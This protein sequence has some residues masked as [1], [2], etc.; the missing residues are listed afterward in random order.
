MNNNTEKYLQISKLLAKELSGTITEEEK[1]CLE[2]LEKE[3]LKDVQLINKIKSP[4][5]LAAKQNTYKE[6]SS[7]KVW[8]MLNTEIIISNS[9]RK[10]RKYDIIIRAVAAIL[11]PIAIFTI[12][13]ISNKPLIK[14]ESKIIQIENT[15]NPILILP[16]EKVIRLDTTPGTLKI[17]GIT[18]PILNSKKS[19]IYKANNKEIDSSCSTKKHILKVPIGKTYKICLSDGTL[20]WL[21]SDSQL[22]YPASFTSNQRHVKLKGEAYFDVSKNKEK[23]FIV[24]TENMDIKVFGTEFNVK[25]YRNDKFAETSLVEG[26]IEVRLQNSNNKVKLIPN[27]QFHF[28]KGESSYKLLDV[29]ASKYALWKEGVFWF[30][31]DKLEDIL[32]SISRWYNLKIFFEYKEAAEVK[33][34]CEIN[35]EINLEKMLRLFEYGS[36][37]KFDLKDKLLIVKR[38]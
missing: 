7:E 31:D 4:D 15:K 33:F 30:S 5:F 24:S 20:V 11:I 17:D 26:S 14:Q 2:I 1:L 12:I 35:K 16:G 29:E 34:S 22:E 37:I 8:K 6:I 19:L 3:H 36:D 10:T 9:R 18:N 25:D 38:K 23:S 21:N 28:T 27:K 13:Y 32:H